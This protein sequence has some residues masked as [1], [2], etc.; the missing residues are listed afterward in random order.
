MKCFN[1]VLRVDAVSVLLGATP[2]ASLSQQPR[3]L[4]LFPSNYEH[5]GEL[6]R[7]KALLLRQLL[8][9]AREL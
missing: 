6:L 2:C 3:F 8:C 5:K 4:S 1:C 7:G 9:S